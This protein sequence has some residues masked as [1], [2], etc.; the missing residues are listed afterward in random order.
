M[1]SATRASRSFPAWPESVPVARRYVSET[2]D[3]VPTELCQTAALLVSELATNVVRHSGAGEFVV[4]LD[5]L[6]EEGRLWV[7]VTDTGTGLPVLRPPSLTAE[8]GRGMRLVATLAD[9]WGAGRR[10]GT[11]GK[12]VWFELRY[13]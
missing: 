3:R 2:L 13:G 4:E 12:T 7:G 5:N 11:T 1:A 8:H 9:R 6:P 10:R